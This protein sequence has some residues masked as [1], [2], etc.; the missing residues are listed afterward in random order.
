MGKLLSVLVGHACKPLHTSPVGYGARVTSVLLLVLALTPVSLSVDLS[1]DTQ[2]RLGSR[3]RELIEARLLEEGFPVESGAKL[4]LGVEE[5]HG[6]LRLW[7]KAGRR[8]AERELKPADEWPAELG[9][10]LAQRLAVLAHEA[11]G[12]VPEAE[13]PRAVAEEGMPSPRPSPPRG[14]GERSRLGAGVRVGVVM[15]PPS[16][17]PTIAF[18]GTVPTGTPLEPIVSVGLVYAPGRGLTAWELPLLAGVRWA[19]VFK[20]L[21]IVPE[22]LGGGRLHLFGPSP[23]DSAGGARFD[24]MGQLGVSIL[25]S[26]G[27]VRLGLRL[28]FE[29]SPAREHLE[30]EDILWSRGGFGTSAM[31]VLER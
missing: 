12:W 20:E 2:A 4:K 6:T 19:I 26:F 16:F 11:E 15:R 31:L 18:H 23:L 24:L 1:R 8:E 22:L 9:F 14:E 25:R 30:G 17:D 13:P 3:V 21:S 28:G 10:E 27:P 5:L 29:L 7:V